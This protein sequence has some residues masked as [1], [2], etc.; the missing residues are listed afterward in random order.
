LQNVDF[1][2][3]TLSVR[4]PTDLHSKLLHAASAAGVK[5]VA[6]NIW[7]TD[8]FNANLLAD[9]LMGPGMTKIL[10]ELEDLKLNWIV[11]VC[12]FWYEWSLALPEQWY[13]F[14]IAERK[15]T[16][17]DDG[18]T[19]INT[20][21]WLQCGRAFAAALALPVTR[22][23]SD[24]D[25]PLYISSFLISQRDMLDSLHR[26]LGT[27]DADWEIRYESTKKRVE[28]G[29]AEM[30]RGDMKGFAKA[31]YARTFFPGKGMG[32]EF[33]GEKGIANDRLGLPREE[34]DEATRRA[35]EMVRSGWDPLRE[36]AM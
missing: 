30:Q 22:S 35:V 5:W 16:M 2:I 18:M 31:M 13:G 1:L 4:A 9:S 34:L 32:A 10:R 27:S 17:Y 14:T 29:K 28:D 11:L 26:V 6:P 23:G 19:R 3:I 7:G 33:E 36:L 15:V 20:S 12:G 8:V 24:A 25:G 21:T